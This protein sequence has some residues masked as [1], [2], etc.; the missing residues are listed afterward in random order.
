LSKFK[1]K[2][3]EAHKVD[4]LLDDNLKMVSF[5]FAK[6]SQCQLSALKIIVNIFE[7]RESNRLFIEE[8]KTLLAK[9]QYKEAGQ[10]A[11]DLGLFNE[12]TIDDFLIPLILEDKLGIVEEYLDKAVQ[13][14]DPTVQ[15]L[16][17]L[18]EKN[19]SVPQM[20]YTY[21]E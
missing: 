9:G 10:F 3:H 21:V 15:F 16:D 7:L 20:C 1:K 13:L 4:N 11:C 6:N 19:T 5:N 14:R 8:I 18:L 17:S 12:F 2:N